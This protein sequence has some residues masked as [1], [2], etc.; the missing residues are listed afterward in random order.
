M[1]TCIY[2]IAGF[3]VELQSQ[4]PYLHELCAGYTAKGP[5]FIDVSVAIQ[6]GDTDFERRK[7][8]QEDMLEGLPVHDYPEDYLEVTAAYRR[9]AHLLL[10]RD[11]LV[12]HGSVVAVDGRA[13]LFTAKSGTGKSTHTALWRKKF[14]QRA[15]MVN[16]DK[17]L[18]RFY[19]DGIK[20][21]GTPWDGKHH[22]S[23]N[24]QVPLHAIC[25]LERD[26]TNHIEPIT[27]AQALPMLMQQSYRPPEREAL[28]RTLKLISR[29]TK[30]VKLYRLGCNMDPEAADVAF[31]GMQED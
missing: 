11:A 17:P 2:D 5:G 8:I 15:V 30:G 19:P 18:L 14:G 26:Q 25:I 4:Y 10:E 24:I 27:V 9:L 16:D 7:S 21:C 28:A 6:P 1:Y 29:L 12:F 20:A 13:Y 31:A 3:R 22:L 23:A